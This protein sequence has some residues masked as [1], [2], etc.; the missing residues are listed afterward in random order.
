MLVRISPIL[1]FSELGSLTIIS[2]GLFTALIAAFAAINQKD[3]KNANK[4]KLKD[5]LKLSKL[6]ILKK[7]IAFLDLV[8]LRIHFEHQVLKLN[9]D[10]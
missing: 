3:I 6:S 9:L 1:Q 10:Q 2:M 4:K 5:N 8:L 7:Y